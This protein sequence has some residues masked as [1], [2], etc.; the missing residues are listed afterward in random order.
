VEFFHG[1]PWGNFHGITGS[2]EK[3]PRDPVSV[4]AICST[5]PWNFSREGR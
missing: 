2:R 1:I 4:Y 5:I 3:M